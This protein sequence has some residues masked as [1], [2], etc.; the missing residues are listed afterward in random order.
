M[1]GHQVKIQV[2]N[3]VSKRVDGRRRVV[4]VLVLFRIGIFVSSLSCFVVVTSARRAV[5]P[6]S[7][8]CC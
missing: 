5:P 1:A 3:C 4:A 6:F 7:T 2:S 8:V